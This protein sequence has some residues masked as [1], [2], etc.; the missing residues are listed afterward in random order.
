MLSWIGS[1]GLFEDGSGIYQS[2]S[3]RV[4]GI[5][6]LDGAVYTESVEALCSAGMKFT[7]NPAKKEFVRMSSAK[8]RFPGPQFRKILALALITLAFHLSHLLE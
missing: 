3:R 4:L 2:A 1:F 5:A 6:P 8:V 7:G